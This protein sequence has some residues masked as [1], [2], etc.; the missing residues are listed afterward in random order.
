MNL[1]YCNWPI[2][3][4]SNPRDT[5]AVSRA[6]RKF[7]S[8]AFSLDPTDCSWVSDDGSQLTTIVN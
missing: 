3:V 2:L 8:T 5:G 4:V 6:G 1:I 7:S